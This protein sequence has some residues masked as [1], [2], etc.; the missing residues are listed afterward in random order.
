M[1]ILSLAILALDIFMAVHVIRT[2]RT[3]WWISIILIVPLIGSLA[4]F[5]V[6]IF[7]TLDFQAKPKVVRMQKA[8]WQRAQAELRQEREVGGRRIDDVVDRGSINDKI[9]LAETCMA[10]DLFGDAVRLYESAREGYFV[11]AADVL[12]GLA[13]AQLENGDFAKCRQT[14]REL[15]EAHPSSF[16]QERAILTAR[17]L[18]GA[19]DFA[20]ATAELESLLERKDSLEARR[21]EAR[22]YYAEFLWKQGMKDRAVAQL[23]EIVRHGKLFNMT[24]EE[25]RWV[26]RAGEVQAALR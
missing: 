23:T 2:G 7:P 12:I 10:R 17:A 16:A 19:G 5:F 20:T 6:E 8:R 15:A 25:E 26:L 4:Y 22:Y 11:N 13:R 18:A 21:L 9:A 3:C 14:L 1:P 24:E